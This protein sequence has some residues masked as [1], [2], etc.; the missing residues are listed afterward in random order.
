MA[1]ADLF[2]DPPPSPGETLIAE[3]LHLTR[4]TMP[5]MARSSHT[6]WPVREDHCFQRIVLD[7]VCGAVW[8]EKIKRPAY[9]HLSG[10]QAAEAVR[11]CRA[12]IDG[13]LSMDALNAQSLSMRGKL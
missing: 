1:R 4:E 9:K 7:A 3:Y 10:E 12:L 2:P 6:H 13:E 11:I 5:F 8:Y